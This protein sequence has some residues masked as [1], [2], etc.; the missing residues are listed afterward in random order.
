MQ[1]N[2][3]ALSNPHISIC[4]TSKPLIVTS[5]GFYRFKSKQSLWTR[6]PEGRSD[7]QLLY[8]ASGKAHFYF[9]G[10]KYTVCAGN[11]VLLQPFQE[12]QYVY[13]LSDKPEVYWLHFTGSDVDLLL[14]RSG[15]P[16]DETYFATGC[17]VAYANLFNEIIHELQTACTGF[18]EILVLNFKKLLLLIHRYREDQKQSISTF[19]R[20]E[21]HLACVYFSENHRQAVCIR[22]YVRSRGMSLSWFQRSFKET[23]GYTPMQYVITIRMNSAKKLLETTDYGIADIAALVG[24]DD[25]LYFSRLFHKHSGASPS[26]YRKQFHAEAELPGR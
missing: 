25:P 1:A 6:R 5:C 19:M 23:T 13:Y 20:Q 10:T 15:I 2:I 17:S 9:S 14:R 16:M 24:Y 22:D 26:V 18:E 4:D 12:Q 8:I 7:Y 21:V 11:M 3:G